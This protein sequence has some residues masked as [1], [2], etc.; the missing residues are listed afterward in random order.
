MLRQSIFGKFLWLLAIAVLVVRVGDAHLHFCADGQEQPM[1]LHVADV[2]GEHHADEA[3]SSH[4]D[5]DLDISEPTLFKKVGG[6]DEMAV[7]A[8]VVYALVVLLPVL[9]R[10]EPIA[11]VAPVALASVFALR[12]PLRGPPR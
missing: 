11:D 5:R 4:D 2:P 6:L 1:T 12:P 7:A 8:P 10:I 9:S 3:T